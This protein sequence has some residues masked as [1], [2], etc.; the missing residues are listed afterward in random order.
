MSRKLKIYEQSMGGGNYTQVP[1]ILLKGKWLEEAG[2]K[3]G[4]YVEVVV[5]GDKITLSKTTPPE[6][7]STK[8]SLEERINKLD[9]K[10]RAKL[11]N[12][13]DKL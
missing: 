11:A 10:Q 9:S 8:K 3:P 5:E 1:T 2:F 6:A 4:E 13:I 12:L 7:K